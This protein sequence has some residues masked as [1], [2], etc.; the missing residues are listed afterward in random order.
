MA[1]TNEDDKGAA[2]YHGG[3]VDTVISVEDVIAQA[4]QLG[5]GAA[6]EPIWDMIEREF[7]RRRHQDNPII[8][9]KFYR[10]DRFS[11]ACNLGLPAAEEKGNIRAQ[12]QARL[13]HH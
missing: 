11:P 3:S 4:E 9:R 13:R 1:A 8:D 2:D 5:D 12:T 7:E 10:P 6:Q